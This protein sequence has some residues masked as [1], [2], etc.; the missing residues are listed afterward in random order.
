MWMLRADVCFENFFGFEAGDTERTGE[1]FRGEVEGFAFKK[2]IDVSH[3]QFREACDVGLDDVDVVLKGA[4][5]VIV[6][7][8]QV[9][10]QALVDGDG[11]G[12]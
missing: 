1:W 10:E 4:E 12:V 7:D 8:F 9:L 5:E 3:G 2:V 6:L 11:V